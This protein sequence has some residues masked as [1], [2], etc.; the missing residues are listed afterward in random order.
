MKKCKPLHSSELKF[1]ISPNSKY[2]PYANSGKMT[3]IGP[4]LGFDVS[5]NAYLIGFSFKITFMPHRYIGF[6]E[7]ISYTKR[8]TGIFQI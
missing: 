5:R 7:L 8:K 1:I 6:N 2:S 4:N 3:L